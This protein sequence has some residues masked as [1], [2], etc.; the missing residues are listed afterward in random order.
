MK[1][2]QTFNKYEN[3]IYDI[4]C[5][6]NVDY[7]K[8]DYLL[9]NGASANAIEIDE[10]DN[11]EV[12]EM[13]LLVQCWLDG[14]FHI[15]VCENKELAQN[16]D[17]NI[18]LLKIFIDNG[19]DCD[20]Y[21]DNIFSHIHF[22]YDEKNFLDMVKLILNNIKDRNNVDLRASL[23]TIGL[24]ESYQNC[25]EADHRYANI[26][27]TVYEMIEKYTQGKDQNK[28]FLCD[29]VVGQRIK[30]VSIFCN[31]LKV[32]FQDKL[33]SDDFDIFIECDEDR[34]TILDK[35]I[36]VNN[37]DIE[38]KFE[39]IYSENR[40][41]KSMNEYCA[42]EIIED[43]IILNEQISTKS[44]TENNITKIII[45]LSNDKRITINMDESLSFMKLTIK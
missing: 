31:D 9:K 17:F 43:I 32:D 30:K 39:R 27:S 19:L 35:Y 45:K 3:E 2:I 36:F 26:I 6:E 23:S 33:I 10:F 11:G 8:I 37:N 42:G 34:L 41:E 44:K 15:S 13:L 21:A 14:S 38:T 16:S 25:C 12:D 18:K 5:S 29:K 40:I 20:K 24:E 22:T 1:N 28:Y 7:E 4:C